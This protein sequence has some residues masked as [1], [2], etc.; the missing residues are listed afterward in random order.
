MKLVVNDHLYTGSEVEIVKELAKQD[1]SATSPQMYKMNVKERL[2]V[3]ELPTNNLCIASASGFINSL[4]DMG[5]AAI[6]EGDE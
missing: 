6:I 3:M 2:R 4:V 1:L 5:L